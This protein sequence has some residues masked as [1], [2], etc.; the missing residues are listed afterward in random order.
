MLRWYTI[1]ADQRLNYSI[2]AAGP[3]QTSHADL[4]IAPYTLGAWL[5]DG[6]SINGSIT[7]ADDDGKILEEIRRDRFSL[8]ERVS[9]RGSGR[10]PVYNITGLMS[11]LLDVGVLGT[12]TSRAS[13][14][15]PLNHS[16]A[17]CWLGSAG[18]WYHL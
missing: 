16:D 13:T 4:S 8:T 2:R 10:T 18:L 5:E 9:A 14:S 6:T 11:K 3:L 12:S 7:N 17:H 15:E 1:E